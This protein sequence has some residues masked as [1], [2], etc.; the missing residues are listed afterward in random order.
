MFP[1]WEILYHLYILTRRLHNY[2]SSLLPQLTTSSINCNVGSIVVNMFLF[3]RNN[4]ARKI[5]KLQILLLVKLHKCHCPKI[6]CF[7]NVIVAYFFKQI[8]N[9]PS[10]KTIEF[11]KIKKSFKLVCNKNIFAI[12]QKFVITS[13]LLLHQLN[14]VKQKTRIN[15]ILNHETY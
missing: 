15:Y 5:L 14:R 7:E 8:K 2:Y 6:S 4:D 1:L 3:F 11:V 12:V 13:V 9:P 10:L